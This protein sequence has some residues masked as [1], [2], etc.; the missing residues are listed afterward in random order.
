MK[1]PTLVLHPRHDALVPFSE[2]R[3]LATLIPGARLVPLESRNHILLAGEP[4]CA[5]FRAELRAFLEPTDNAI[6]GEVSELTRP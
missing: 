4:A 3:L 5:H 1:S 6:R 2:G